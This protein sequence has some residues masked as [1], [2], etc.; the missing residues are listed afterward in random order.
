[1]HP[2]HLLLESAADLERLI[3]PGSSEYQ[4]MKASAI[5]RQLFLDS[6][7]LVHLVNRDLRQ[8][9]VFELSHLK[10]NDHLPPL[11]A[12]QPEVT[13]SAVESLGK[14][15]TGVTLREFLNHP[16]ITVRGHS[17]TVKNIIKCA[18]HV[19]GGVHAAPPDDD[20]EANLYKFS[21]ELEILDRNMLMHSLADI[22]RVSLRG[23]QPILSA[24]RAA[25]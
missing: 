6:H 25:P 20:D 11:E 9:L 2:Y 13:Y 15:Q 17:Y 18:A 5:L 14:A 3:T 4:L 10:P 1:M 12:G 19:G 23:L 8:P 24:A 22:G 7:P 21:R 16:T